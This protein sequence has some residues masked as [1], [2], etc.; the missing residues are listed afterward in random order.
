[1]RQLGQLARQLLRGACDPTIAYGGHEGCPP[2]GSSG[3]VGRQVKTEIALCAT[4]VGPVPY[5]LCERVVPP[6]LGPGPK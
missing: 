1:M 6:K 3:G 5:V 2:R 4:S